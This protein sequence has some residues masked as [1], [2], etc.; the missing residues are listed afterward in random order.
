[1]TERDHQVCAAR[2]PRRAELARQGARRAV[3]W[4]SFWVWVWGV[5]V[6]AA[7]E[8]RW[9]HPEPHGNNLADL[10][11]RDGVYLHVTDH[12]GVY[13]STNRLVWERRNTG[14][15]KDLR[16]AAFL[17]GR[18]IVSGEEGTVL[19]SDDLVQFQSGTVNPAT[20]DWLEGVA[21]TTNLAVAV[22]DQGAVYRSV[23]GRAWERVA[24]G[25]FTEWLFGV[26]QG[27]GLFVLVGEGGLIASSSDGVTW[28]RRRSGTTADLNRVAYGDGRFLAVGN[29]GVVLSSSNGSAWTLE[30]SPTYTNPLAAAALSPGERLVMGDSAL[31]L[32][33][34]PQVWQDQ[35]SA[36]IS[37]IPA[38]D[39]NYAAAVWDG[40]RYLVGGRT[41]VLVESF[42]TNAP[43][44]EDATSWVRQDESPR[45]WLWDVAWVG[46]TYL[47][48]GDEATILSSLSGVQWGLESV[49]E[50]L[51]G[52]VLFGVGGSEDEA[53][54]V[55]EGGR[56]LRSAVGFTNV[57]V[58]RDVVVGTVTNTVWR[59]NR[60]SLTGLIWELVE[61]SPT[62]NTL[63]GI[64]WDGSRFVVVG[65]GGTI[66]TGTNTTQ[67]A[68]SVAS[69]K[70]FLS[71]VAAANGQWVAS[72]ARGAIYTSPDASAWTRRDSGTTNWVY[73]VAWVGSEWVAVGESGVIRTSPDGVQWTP[74][75]SGTTAWL[76]GIQAM[77]D[78]VYVC[79]TQGTVLRSTN[80]VDWVSVPTLTGKALY[81][82]AHR[83]PQLVVAG[84]EGVILRA[85]AEPSL[86]AVQIGGYQHFPGD[87]T[88]VEALTFEGV[89]EQPF[90]WE[91]GEALGGWELE[92]ER[93]LDADGVAISG[94]ATGRPSRFHRA[95]TPP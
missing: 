63:Q 70:E 89:A 62:T 88:G 45:N 86:A 37:P 69:G 51:T 54:V 20:T 82:V 1:M 41:G 42:R 85:I 55:G 56:M 26:A 2:L 19:W 52:M 68:S 84:A 28:T 59:T 4:A 67:W 65:A 76:T 72:G 31:I 39:W 75:A 93:E 49:P 60:L 73:R 91:S 23:D 94:K 53:L 14:T 46:G 27:D 47:A 61:T 13:A 16:G 87:P 64:G 36:T 9:S 43:P 40:T 48:V 25:D 50:S 29:D 92:L 78:A 81:G 8:W 10:V 35:L 11:Y 33:R 80:R 17:G 24:I 22:G 44:F 30:S 3:F 12:G 83:G 18:F 66:L 58:G 95:V 74:R 34:P 21:A 71:S 38:P 6:S 90:R 7:A 57:V 32:R 77:G 79:G 15:L 5:V